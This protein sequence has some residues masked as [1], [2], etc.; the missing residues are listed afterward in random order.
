VLTRRT[1]PAPRARDATP[2]GPGTC[3][4]IDKLLGAGDRAAMTGLHVGIFK[5][6]GRYRHA[7]AHIPAARDAQTRENNPDRRHRGDHQS[8][9]LIIPPSVCHGVGNGVRP[10]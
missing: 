6:P 9:A 8:E 5:A 10:G 1:S 3:I 7:A 4:E 2:A